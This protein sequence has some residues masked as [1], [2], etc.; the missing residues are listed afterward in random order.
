MYTPDEI[1]QFK[2]FII[3]E[4]IG[5]K[6]LESLIRNDV[7]MNLPSS[8]TIYGWLRETTSTG[9]ANSKYD[10]EFFSDYAHARAIRASKI[11][12][13]MLTIADDG[14]NDTY[15]DP[16]SGKTFTDYDVVQRSKLRVDTRKWILA[17]M[18]SKRFGDKIETTLQ[19]GDKPI[20]TVDYSKLS[21]NALEEIAKLTSSKHGS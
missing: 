12:D 11:F 7:D 5:G 3:N 13:D 16:E 2:A 4:V 20:Q 1:K 15:V 21:D 14:S 9:E 18:D 19:G 17:R 10:A 6:S 8:P